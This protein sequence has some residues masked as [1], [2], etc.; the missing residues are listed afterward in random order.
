MKN[1]IYGYEVIVFEHLSL[2]W[3][4]KNWYSAKYKWG[5]LYIWYTND[6]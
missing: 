4:W 6:L 3:I 5:D 2:Y 1:I